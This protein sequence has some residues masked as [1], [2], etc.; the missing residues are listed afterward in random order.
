M[1]VLLKFLMKNKV[2]KE[3]KMSKWKNVQ[4]GDTFD[5]RGEAFDDI[6]D[7]ISPSDIIYYII[8]TAEEKDLV[9]ALDGKKPDFYTYNLM[10][11]AEKQC[12]K[13]IAEIPDEEEENTE[14]N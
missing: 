14:E 3:M 6:F 1:I 5:S 11:F 8:E 12:D 2:R 13:Y 9:A 4:T 7:N 10:G